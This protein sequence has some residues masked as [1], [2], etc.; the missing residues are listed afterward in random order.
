VNPTQLNKY[1]LGL[2]DVRA[3]WRNANANRPKGDFAD[4]NHLG[5]ISTTDQLLKAA[6][7][8]R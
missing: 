7:Y 5:S 2:E 8:R 1:G 4:D 6:E 3:C